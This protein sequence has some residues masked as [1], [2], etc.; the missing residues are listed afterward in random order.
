MAKRKKQTS[1]QKAVKELSKTKNGR[2]ILIIVAIILIGAAVFGYFYYKKK[3]QEAEVM[4]FPD[5]GDQDISIHFLELGNKYAG[6][7]VY[8]KTEDCDILIDCGSRESSVPTV[9]KYLEHY[10]TDGTIEY[11]IVTHAHQDHYAGFAGN[12]KYKSI[13]EYFDFEV[14]IDFAGT[15][16]GKTGQ[17]M[18]QRYQTSLAQEVEAGATHYT[19]LQCVNE[20]DGAS[21]TYNIGAGYTMKILDSYYYANPDTSNENNNSVC[22]LFSNGTKNYL[23]TGDLEQEGEEKLLERN[24]LPEVDLFKAGHHGSKTSSSSDFLAVIKPKTVVVCCCAGSPEYTKT[25]SNQFPTQEFLT[26][27]H[28]Y[29]DEIYVTTLYTGDSTKSIDKTAFTSFNGNVVYM[30]K[31]DVYKVVCS[32]SSVKLKDSEWFKKNR[33][34]A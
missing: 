9:Q 18:Y 33:T 31:G 4:N 3:T 7:C 6:D 11:T 29:T 2:I 32:A 16:N 14:V 23:F 30:A 15:T 26:N 28:S 17:A 24:T 27:V 34:W 20:T 13:F 10:V 8:I 1:T 22:C 12:T 21:T 19:A 5:V 25:N